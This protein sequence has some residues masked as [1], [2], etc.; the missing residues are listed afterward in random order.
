MHSAPG[1]S[2]AA[3][4]KRPEFIIRHGVRFPDWHC[5]RSTNAEAAL[6]TM[7]R[8]VRVERR[9]TDYAPGLDRIRT[10]IL[11]SFATRGHAP[12]AAELAA[13]TGVPTGEVRSVLTELARR[14]LVVLGEHGQVTGAYPFTEYA[15]GHSVRR[16]DLEVRAMCA[17]DA[18]GIGAMLRE[19]VEIRSSCRA[20]G[21][22]VRI[23]TAA[24]G[25]ALQSIEP[26]E[27]VVRV[28]EV[29]DGNCGATSLCT[30]IA[31]FCSDGH[32]DR[33]CSPGEAKTAHRLTAGE[34][35]QIGSAI[36]GP[37]LRRTGAEIGNGCI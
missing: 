1:S 14:D 10:A 34:A 20:C 29:Y 15:T 26:A 37:M 5:I 17:I 3:G 6:L 36:F 4:P 30:S 13:G 32:L 19:D 31:F 33:W 25:T 35:H 2:G 7:F 27:A 28:G 11:R 24:E 16:D 21:A 8:L 18:L 12:H 9:W 22:P 23:T